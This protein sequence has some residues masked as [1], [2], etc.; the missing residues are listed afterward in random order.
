ML[1]VQ[2]L[3]FG[4]GIALFAQLLAPIINSYA[5]DAY[6]DIIPQ[7]DVLVTRFLHHDFP[8][9]AIYN[10]GYRLFPT[11]QPLQWM[12]FC[13]P[14]MLGIDFRWFAFAFF[15]SVLLIYLAKL[16]KEG[17]NPLLLAVLTILPFW[18]LRNL[19]NADHDMFGNTVEL[20][21]A[22]YYLLLAFSATTTSIWAIAGGILLCLL[23]RY[24]LIFWLPL[25]F[26]VLLF[27]WDR[28]KT[29]WAAALVLAGVVLI[30]VLPFMTHDWTIFL[31]GYEYHSL[32]AYGEWTHYAAGSNQ[33]VHLFCGV[34][35]AGFFYSF[36]GGNVEH[37]L[38]LVQMVHLAA[39]TLTISGLAFWYFRQLKGSVPIRLFLLCSLKIYLVV[40]YT[41]IQIPYAYLMVTPL[42]ATLP[43]LLPQMMATSDKRVVK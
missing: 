31:Q 27:S 14:K 26:F 29:L 23:S 5:I 41:F 28:I 39:C 12:P 30:Y 6:S 13:I 7:M 32:A 17:L 11:Y 10:W 22:A 18:T 43:L 42:F 20:L 3:L 15:V 37:R 40:F 2:V 4:G 19:I 36:A 34:G 9:K 1:A 33:P 35:F 38:K 21:I 16:N 24:S 25:Y 8:Y